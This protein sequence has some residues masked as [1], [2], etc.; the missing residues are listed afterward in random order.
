MAG[1]RAPQPFPFGY[2]APA[3]GGGWRS[4]FLRH[5]GGLCAVPGA[6]PPPP[7]PEAFAGGWVR[8]GRIRREEAE[9]QRAEADRQAREALREREQRI[10][11]ARSEAVAAAERYEALKERQQ[12]AG[13]A[14]GRAQQRIAAEVQRELLLAMREAIR[15]AE[16][17]RQLEDDQAVELLLIAACSM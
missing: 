4:A 11:E 8:A 9:R 2:A 16:L 13:R 7:A 17:V 5:L 10:A 12:A 6:A 1:W 14:R 15:T 3:T